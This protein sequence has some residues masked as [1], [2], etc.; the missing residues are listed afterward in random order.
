[1]SDKYLIGL[2]LI[3]LLYILYLNLRQ[4]REIRELTKKLIERDK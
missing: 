4:A 2:N 1:M 3:F